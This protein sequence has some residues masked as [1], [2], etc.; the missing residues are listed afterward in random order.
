MHSFGLI[1]P[2]GWIACTGQECAHCWHG[3]PHCQRR[4]SHSNILMRAGMASAAPSG[5][6]YL[7]YALLTKSPAPRTPTAKST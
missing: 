1:G 4:F 5:Q 2:W 3:L 6:R 7:Q